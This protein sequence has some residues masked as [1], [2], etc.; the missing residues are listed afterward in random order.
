MTKRGFLKKGL[1]MAGILAAVLSLAGCPKE[2]G[3]NGGG[4]SGFNIASVEGTWF[5]SQINNYNIGESIVISSDSI[6]QTRYDNS[7]GTS[8][9]QF[10]GDI[11]KTLHK[12]SYVGI[13]GKKSSNKYR[14]YF[15][16]NINKNSSIEIAIFNSSNYNS[17]E[18]AE[19]AFNDNSHPGMIQDSL[20]YHTYTYQ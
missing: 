20:D 1:F 7:D 2:A 15:L 16:K 12:N 11:V 3:G 8:V 5:C 4:E 13:I 10:S 6:T 14:L 17:L 18:A 19:G 9:V